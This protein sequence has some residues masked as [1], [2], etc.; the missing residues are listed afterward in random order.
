M[1]LESGKLKIG[2]G[3]KKAEALIDLRG[4]IEEFVNTYD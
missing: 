2:F 1:K 4:N 3:L